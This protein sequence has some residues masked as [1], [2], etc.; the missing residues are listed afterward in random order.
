MKKIIF[1]L[2]LLATTSAHA[3]WHH[4]GGHYYWRPGYGWVV[5]AVIGGAIVYEATR[6]V[7]PE[8]VIVQPQPVAPPPMV[9]PNAPP[10]GYH[11]EAVLDARCNCYRA[12][13]VQN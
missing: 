8:V 11:W 9:V 1:A 5:P 3:Q 13:M 10:Y 4:G 12:V 6:P 7:P 2:A